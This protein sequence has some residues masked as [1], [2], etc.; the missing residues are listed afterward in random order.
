ML[1]RLWFNPVIAFEKRM[2]YLTTNCMYCLL[3]K[4]FMLPVYMYTLLFTCVW[5]RHRQETL[6]AAAVSCEHN[7][8]QS[9][10]SHT[11]TSYEQFSLSEIN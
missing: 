2:N 8:T 3:I 7:A 10:L 9:T 4:S 6:S 11:Y 1:L 5:H